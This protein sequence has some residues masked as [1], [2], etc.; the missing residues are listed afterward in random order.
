MRYTDLR[1]S[2]NDPG[3]R[4]NITLLCKGVALEEREEVVDWEH[5][6]RE[7]EAGA[8]GADLFADS[9]VREGGCGVAGFDAGEG[10]GV[11]AGDEGVPACANVGGVAVVGGL[12]DE[13]TEVVVAGLVGILVVKLRSFVRFDWGFGGLDKVTY[14]VNRDEWTVEV[15][16]NLRSSF[17]CDA[18]IIEETLEDVALNVG[19]VKEV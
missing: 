10:F 18:A 1:E 5:G 2:V 14:S 12:E 9:F 8:Q 7:V 11:E 16:R 19:D 15:L 6:F 13:D 3:L 4:P 17:W